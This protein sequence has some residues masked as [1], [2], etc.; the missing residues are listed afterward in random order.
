KVSFLDQD[1]DP[2]SGKTAEIYQD[3]VLMT[4]EKFSSKNKGVFSFVAKCE[5]LSSDAV[6]VKAINFFDLNT[7]RNMEIVI[8][9]SEWD[10]MTQDMLEYESKF[11]PSY[12]L[13]KWRTENYRKAKIVLRDADG[14]FEIDEVGIRTKGNTS[15]MLP[16]D[17]DGLFHRAAFK[18]K[19]DKAFSDLVKGTDEYD[20]R[21]K[22]S[23]LNMNELNLKT[24]DGRNI[25]IRDEKEYI[26]YDWNNPMRINALYSYRKL[27]EASIWA[28]RSN[29]IDLVIRIKN[30]DSKGDKVLD[31]GIYFGLEEVD[32]KFVSRRVKF[33]KN[34]KDGDLYK[35]LYQQGGP[36]TL[37]K[38]P[39]EDNKELKERGLIGEKDGAVDYRPTYDI[40]TNEDTTDHHALKDFIRNLNNLTGDAFVSYMDANFD[41]DMFLK[42]IAWDVLLGNPDGYFGNAQNYYLYFPPAGTGYKI[43]FI[44]CDLDHSVGAG[45]YPT[46]MTDIDIYNFYQAFNSGVKEG[47]R[48][49]LPLVEKLLAVTKYKK[50]YSD[51]LAACTDAAGGKFNYADFKGFYDA[52]YTLYTKDVDHFVCDVDLHRSWF[53]DKGI[54]TFEV[55][56]KD[57]KS[58]MHPY[59]IEPYSVY[60]EASGTMIDTIPPWAEPG[61]TLYVQDY[62]TQKIASVRTQLGL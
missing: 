30:Y 60:D 44:P 48:R 56:R 42:S 6:K 13:C 51:Y 22:R 25:E 41:V 38:L 53:D 43:T 5:G 55:P 62:F 29:S 14:D 52:C 61:K 31:Y 50:V 35:C 54:L 34:A 45:W 24:Y 21:K 15:R 37:E 3:G 32:K 19:F 46:N 7:L 23:F 57:S 10:G 27:N 20:Q 47:E 11:P 17:Q 33:D 40:A 39:T 26:H 28:P 4:K 9:K 2:M 36:A 59:C 8:S 16:Q 1:G 18:L 58:W 12:Y 49:K